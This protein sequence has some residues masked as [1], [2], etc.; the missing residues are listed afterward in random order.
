MGV[1]DMMV[2]ACSCPAHTATPG[3]RSISYACDQDHLPSG[4]RKAA[5]QARPTYAG[6]SCCFRCRSNSD[7]GSSKQ[8]SKSDKN[9]KAWLKQR[10]LDQLKWIKKLVCV[11]VLLVLYVAYGISEPMMQWRA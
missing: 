4:V 9:T 10:T 7:S 5:I 3:V 8:I 2:A 11:C 6:S 1:A